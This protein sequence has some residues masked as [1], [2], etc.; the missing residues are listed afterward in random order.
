MSSLPSSGD[1]EKKKLVA[2]DTLDSP[3]PSQTPSVSSED[4]LSPVVVR[5]KRLLWNDCGTHFRD[6]CFVTVVVTLCI[7]SSA[8]FRKCT[9]NIQL[10]VV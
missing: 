7:C 2:Q 10:S 4:P 6:A 1:G 5:S 9:G 3:S 8:S